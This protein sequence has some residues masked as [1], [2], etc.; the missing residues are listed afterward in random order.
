MTRP[1]T[2]RSGLPLEEQF[3]GPPSKLGHGLAK[4]IAVVGAPGLEPLASC[5]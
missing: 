2:R 5:V 1:E 4:R 3:D